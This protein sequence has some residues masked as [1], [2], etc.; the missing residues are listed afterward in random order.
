MYEL[1]FSQYY[2]EVKHCTQFDY[3]IFPPIQFLL[4]AQSQIYRFFIL[5]SSSFLYRLTFIAIYVVIRIITSIDACFPS[6]F[7]LSSEINGHL[8]TKPLLLLIK[9]GIHNEN[10]TKKKKKKKK[11]LLLNFNDTT[12]Y[13]RIFWYLRKPGRQSLPFSSFRI[14]FFITILV[15]ICCFLL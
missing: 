14:F 9:Q 15:P 1:F 3:H 5:K 8:R 6:I 12:K 2:L 10:F 7:L 4:D 13:I 11:I